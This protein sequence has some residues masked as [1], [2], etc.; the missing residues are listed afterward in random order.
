MFFLEKKVNRYYLAIYIYFQRLTAI[1]IYFNNEKVYFI[2]K[3]TFKSILLTDFF[4]KK[5]KVS[6]LLFSD[7]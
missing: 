3:L 6:S 5:P 7:L 4:F 2:I 1:Y